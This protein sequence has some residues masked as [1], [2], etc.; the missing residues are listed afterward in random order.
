MF[1]KAC[2]IFHLRNPDVQ[3]AREPECRQTCV[4]LRSLLRVL[5]TKPDERTCSCEAQFRVHLD[6]R[7]LNHGA[8]LHSLRTPQVDCM[9]FMVVWALSSILLRTGFRTK[10]T[11]VDWSDSKGSHRIGSSRWACHFHVR[12]RVTLRFTWLWSISSSKIER[13]H[14]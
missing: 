6:F 4:R 13:V 1:R 14:V 7:A 10:S 3:Q 9:P 8:N 2:R 12:Q 11:R 5:R